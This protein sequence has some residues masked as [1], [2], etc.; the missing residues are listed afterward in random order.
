M[1]SV[2]A[3]HI[4]PTLSDLAPTKSTGSITGCVDFLIGHAKNQILL[5]GF[6]WPID[7]GRLMG[8]PVFVLRVCFAAAQ[9]L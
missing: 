2:P 9:N 1:D 6:F 3:D 7:T 5:G 8:D 4:L